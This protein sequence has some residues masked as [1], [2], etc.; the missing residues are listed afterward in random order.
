MNPKVETL[1]SR[2]MSD[3]VKVGF[4]LG[5]NPMTIEEDVI[6]SIPKQVVQYYCEVPTQ[7]RLLYLLAF[8][9]A[10][11]AEKVI[12]FVSNCE[13]ANFLHAL[14]SKFDFN[15]IGRRVEPP[16]VKGKEKQEPE[17]KPA[18]QLY[19][20]NVCKLHGEMEHEQ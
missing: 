8:L 20:G 6:G 9:Y 14:I 1:G 13:L 2:L 12:V 4:N 15:R 16:T 7:Y 18:Q 5:D 11:Q 3:Y 19:Q 10:H 17:A